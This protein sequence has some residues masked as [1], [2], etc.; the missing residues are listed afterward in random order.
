M[1][2]AAKMMMPWMPA[3]PAVENLRANISCVY[4]NKFG[5]TAAK[6]GGEGKHSAFYLALFTAF[7]IRY[8]RTVFPKN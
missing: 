5:F 2:I 6:R 7:Q 4:A 1:D 8:K 3:T